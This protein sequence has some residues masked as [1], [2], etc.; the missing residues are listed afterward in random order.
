MESEEVSTL[1]DIFAQC[2]FGIAAVDATDL[3]VYVNEAFAHQL[4]YSQDELEGMLLPTL[5]SPPHNQDFAGSFPVSMSSTVVTLLHRDEQ[6]VTSLLWRSTSGEIPYYLLTGPRPLLSTLRVH[7]FDQE[8][9]LALTPRQRDIVAD[10]LAGLSVS[11][12]AHRRN[13]SQHTVRN[14][15]KAV[16]RKLDLHSRSELFAHFGPSVESQPPVLREIL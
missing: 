2:P 12:I 10:T 3:L 9:M 4:G 5:V 14:H 1:Q 16:Y 6:L 15:L 8:R 7:S 13:I 11:E